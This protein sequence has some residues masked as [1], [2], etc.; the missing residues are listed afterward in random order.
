MEPQ[1]VMLHHSQEPVFDMQPSDLSPCQFDDGKIVDRGRGKGTTLSATGLNNPITNEWTIMPDS[2][3]QSLELEKTTGRPGTTERRWR[4][5]GDVAPTQQRA[6]AHGCTFTAY[7][8]IHHTP[9]QEAVD[10]AAEAFRTRQAARVWGELGVRHQHPPQGSYD[11]VRYD[12]HR[13]SPDF[14]HT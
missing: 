13:R 10:P 2:L 7:D 1:S 9:L 3:K 12:E 6:R 5:N 4:A 8:P 11:P 14:S